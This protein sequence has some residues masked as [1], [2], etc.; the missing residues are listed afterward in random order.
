MMI[1]NKSKH[2]ASK[3]NTSYLR[4]FGFLN[5]QNLI[6]LRISSRKTCISP[7]CWNNRRQRRAVQAEAEHLKAKGLSYVQTSP[8]R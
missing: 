5:K 8:I 6:F 4:G 2:Q 7:L 3:K 1:K